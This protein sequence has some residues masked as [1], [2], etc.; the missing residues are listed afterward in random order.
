MYSWIKSRSLSPPEL[1]VGTAA[2]RAQAQ[3]SAKARDGWLFVLPWDPMAIGGVSRVV[4]ELASSLSRGSSFD[5]HILVL[6]WSAHEPRYDRTRNATVIRFRVRDRGPLW[7][8]QRLLYIL[9]LPRVVLTLR[10]LLSQMRVSVVNV[11]YPT[12]Q[13]LELLRT[14][15]W[16][17]PG[18]TTIVSCHGIDV[19]QLGQMNA[20]SARR[21]V[22]QLQL[23]DTV[24]VCSAG[25]L[26][27]LQSSLDSALTNAAVRRNGAT[28]WEHTPARASDAGGRHTVLSVGTYHRNKGHD[29]L[30]RAFHLI[31]ATHPDVNLVIAGRTGP[32]LA[33]LATSL[34][35]RGLEGRVTLRTDVAL[36]DMWSVYDG[37]LI[38]VSASRFEPFGIAMLEAAP[39][40]FPSSPR[41]RTGR[42]RYCATGTTA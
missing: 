7:S 37:A 24:T 15:R 27:R 30:I 10:R 29:V 31:A 16:I 13:A 5:P 22:E 42:G 20:R 40:A 2:A 33:E 1:Q 3:A 36:D 17:E 12:E 39:P 18:V 4:N 25:L 26:E 6:D 14:I 35:E 8:R 9:S 28:R 21:W 23:A 34:R 11:H 32:A 19:W 41:I 38:F